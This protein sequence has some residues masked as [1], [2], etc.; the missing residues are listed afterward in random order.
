MSTEGIVLLASLPIPL[1]G[2]LFWHLKVRA[3]RKLLGDRAGNTSYYWFSFQVQN[4]HL[5]RQLFGRDPLGSLPDELL[6]QVA[7]V[8]RQIG[9]ATLIMACWVLFVFVL[10]GLSL[11]HSGMVPPGPREARPDDRLQHQTKDAQLR[12]GESRDSGFDASHRP[13]MT[14]CHALTPGLS[15]PRTQAFAGT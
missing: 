4:P 10:I 3:L 15:S 14:L 11:R 13:G 7:A 5:S 12:I 8:R 6:E 1:A 9:Y 2:I